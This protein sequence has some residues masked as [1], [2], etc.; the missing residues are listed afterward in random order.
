M[1]WLLIALYIILIAPVRAGVEARWAKGLPS[2]QA[3][4]AV[5]G[6]RVRGSLHARRDKAGRL[7]LT[8]VLGKRPL[9]LRLGRGRSGTA[10][11]TL[12]LLLKSNQGRAA[13]KGL[14]SVDR[15]DV[16]FQIGGSDAASAALLTGLLS[17]L[18]PLLPSGNFRCRPSFGGETRAYVLCIAHARL[19]TLLAAWLR[20]RMRKGADRKEEKAWTI[21]SET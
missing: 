16:F 11:K 1:I 3:G 12:G 2:L 5:W 4:V 13:L 10:L 15:L 17:A 9:P 19:G 7:L 6:V 14:V 8:G 21:Q 18:R 20:W